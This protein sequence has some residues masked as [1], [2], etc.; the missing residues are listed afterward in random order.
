[1]DNSFLNPKRLVFKFNEHQQ[2]GTYQFEGASESTE[3]PFA[4][5]LEQELSSMFGASGLFIISAPEDL[6]RVIYR[7]GA[8]GEREEIRPEGNNPE[9]KYDDLIQKMGD[10]VWEYTTGRKEDPLESR[11]LS[12]DEQALKDTLPTTYEDHAVDV[13]TVYIGKA[14]DMEIPGTIDIEEK[15]TEPPTEPPI[16]TRAE[17]RVKIAEGNL[18][19]RSIDEI[20]EAEGALDQPEGMD[21]AVYLDEL[22]QYLEWAQASYLFDKQVGDSA[23]TEYRIVYRVDE[24]RKR[25]YQLFSNQRTPDEVVKREFE[26]QLDADLEESQEENIERKEVMNEATRERIAN[27]YQLEIS[28]SRGSKL[29]K[30]LCTDPGTG[31]SNRSSLEI[32]TTVEEDGSRLTA[33]I[34]GPNGNIE[35]K[36]DDP[37]FKNIPNQRREIIDTIDSELTGLTDKES[38]KY[39]ETVK[40]ALAAREKEYTPEKAKDREKSRKRLLKIEKD[41][42]QIR[43]EIRY[44]SGSREIRLKAKR[45]RLREE[46]ATL[47]GEKFTEAELEGEDRII[48]VRDKKPRETQE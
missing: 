14:R 5:N 7:L 29:A 11:E 10:A 40:D 42:E 19:S 26:K 24:G 37:K 27:A 32:S 31:K 35:F 6:S 17:E 38:D 25:E 8:S 16:D 18:R 46:A 12:T 44:A 39:N 13:V 1:M 3:Y 43:L 21:K 48:Y 33:N 41:L 36:I 34:S 9:E 28:A 22:R 30:Y 15:N 45:L 2:H 47:L 20:M 4:E 23:I